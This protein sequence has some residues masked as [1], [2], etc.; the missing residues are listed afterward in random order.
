MTARV[1][2]VSRPGGQGPP[3]QWPWVKVYV[4]CAEPKEHKYLRPGIRPGGLGTQPGGSVTG[5]TEKLFMCQM[6]IC[7]FRPL[8]A[9]PP[10]PHSDI[11]L[12]WFGSDFGGP[13]G[14]NSD[15]RAVTLTLGPK[16]LN[17]FTEKLPSN[18]FPGV[19]QQSLLSGVPERCRSKR[20]LSQKHTHTH[21]GAKKCKWVQKSA[22][23][24]PRKS[25]KE[26]K[27]VQKSASA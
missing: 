13:S 10:K 23:A 11:C 18:N 3:D 14:C 15:F 26:C 20:G 19:L 12:G 1:G 6:F 2:V 16:K 17:H 22:N 24:S 5:V 7:L 25:A 8:S 9:E 4:L 27:R 21:M